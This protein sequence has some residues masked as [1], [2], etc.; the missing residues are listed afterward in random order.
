MKT[1]DSAAEPRPQCARTKLIR[2]SRASGDAR[3]RPRAHAPQRT[4]PD[5]RSG[6]LAASATATCAPCEAPNKLTV[7]APTAS[8]TALSTDTCASKLRSVPTR[9][10]RPHPAL[11]CRT[12]VKR[13]ESLEKKPRNES[14]RSEEQTTEIPA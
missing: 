4:S 1:L 14:I 2:D 9:S 7:F 8:A 10:D 3:S 6:F 12:T 13:L 11:S 5:T